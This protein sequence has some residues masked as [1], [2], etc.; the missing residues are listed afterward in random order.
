[1]LLV[2]LAKKSSYITCRLFYKHSQ[3]TYCTKWCHYNS[4][5]V[6]ICYYDAYNST[7]RLLHIG[8]CFCLLYVWVNLIC[9]YRILNIKRNF[10]ERIFYIVIEKYAFNYTY[11]KYCKSCIPQ[12]I[13]I[14]ISFHAISSKLISS[15]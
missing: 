1:M 10:K 5:T 7:T 15:F 8:K 3:C 4:K 9:F 11:D 6:N 14:F 2:S 13:F 12:I